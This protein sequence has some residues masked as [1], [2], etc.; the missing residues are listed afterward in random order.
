MFSLVYNDQKYKVNFEYGEQEVAFSS[1]KN[2]PETRRTTKC[3][4]FVK[5]ED[6]TVPDK[7]AT[8]TRVGEATAICNS[9]DMFSRSMGRK[10]AMAKLLELVGEY[11]TFAGEDLNLGSKDFR[12]AMWDEYFK[13]TKKV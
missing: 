1:T 4:L 13:H 7:E 12:I 8:F 5:N 2:L 10:V 9:S 6:E 11:T 3:I